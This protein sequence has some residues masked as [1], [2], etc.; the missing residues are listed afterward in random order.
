MS[1]DGMLRWNGRYWIYL[2]MRFLYV[3]VYYYFLPFS[4]IIYNYMKVFNTDLRIVYVPRINGEFDAINVT[5]TT[6]DL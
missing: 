2:V 4:V 3:S 5:P 1:K 6:G